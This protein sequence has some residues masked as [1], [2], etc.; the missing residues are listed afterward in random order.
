M[1]YVLKDRVFPEIGAW[2]DELARIRRDIHA[3]PELGFE[4]PRTVALLKETL[5]GWGITELDDT[6]VKG[7][8]IA[9]IEGGRPGPTVALRADIDA[10]PMPDNSE[11][12]WKSTTE[13]RCHACGHDGHATWLLGALRYLNEKRAGFAGRVVGLF[14]PAEEIGRGALAVVEA[15]VLEKYGVKEIYGAHD[16]PT[17]EKG[18]FGL[19]G[20]PAQASTDFFYITVRGRGVHAARPHLGIDPIPAAGLLIG[21]LQTIVSRKVMPIQPAVVSI[22]SV[23][24]GRFG[25]PNVIPEEVTLSGTVRTFNEDVRN[26][27]EREMG[28]MVETVAASEGCTGELRYDRLVPALINPP[29]SIEHVRAFITRQFGA[30]AAGPIDVS[31]GGEDFSEYVNRIPGAMIRVGIRD[32]AHKA[33]LHHPTFDFNDEVIPAAATMLAGVALDRLAALGR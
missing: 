29:E 4:T 23:N 11:N 33:A 28:R 7:G 19:L 1:D 25:T 16:E 8:L 2:A 12:A 15:G 32:E 24:G 18:R 5:A 22:S 17:I 26:Q 9:V 10:L 30:E 31:M 3:H 21:A 13:M 14:Q 27:I 20:G 6:I